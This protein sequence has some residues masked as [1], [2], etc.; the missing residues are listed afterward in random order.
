[1]SNKPTPEVIAI[2]NLNF[3]GHIIPHEWYKHLKYDSGNTNVNAI[4]LLSEIVYWYRPR[5]IKDETT[6]QLLEYHKRF[7]G[8]KLQM[9]TGAFADHFGLSKKQVRD[10]LSFLEDKGL[11][12]KEMRT[13]I[14]KSGAIMSNV[15]FIGI[16]PERIKEI[17]IIKDDSP[18]DSQVIPSDA[19]VIPSDSQVTP[20]IL[21]SQT[22]T[23]ITT[24]TTTTEIKE[25][26]LQIN[27]ELPPYEHTSLLNKWVYL[28]QP[29]DTLVKAV[30]VKVTPKRLRLSVVG[31]D[32]SKMYDPTGHI[33]Y[34][35][36][37]PE[38][39]AVVIAD[40]SEAAKEAGLTPG[41]LAIKNTLIDLMPQADFVPETNTDKK[42][43]KDINA[44]AISA[45]QKGLVAENFERFGT[46]HREVS[47]QGKPAPAIT[48]NII[49]NNWSEFAK[50]EEEQNG[51]SN[52]GTSTSS[53]G[54]QITDSPKYKRMQAN[55]GVDPI[56]F[57]K[58]RRSKAASASM[59]VL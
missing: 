21:Q 45:D 31:V 34:Q 6:G 22:Y 43:M 37:Y 11:I 24:E 47:W 12:E 39:Q 13:V 5:V 20:S 2:G 50:Y 55:G 18:S 17:T 32:G 35:N 46:W 4:I 14:T 30:V 53:Q 26:Q 15:Q 57:E 7:A 59:P 33:F 36:G 49:R 54:T 1:M 28:K 58:A 44:A 10:A 9:S 8:D 42:R 25:E 40:E 52:G 19:E 16:Y 48:L 56:A 29:D 23:E 41:A 38:L 3:I 51:S 27:L